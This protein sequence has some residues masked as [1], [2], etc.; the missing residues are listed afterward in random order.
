MGSSTVN[1]QRKSQL[2]HLVALPLMMEALVILEGNN[3]VST[4]LV[5]SGNLSLQPVNDHLK[6]QIGSHFLKSSVVSQ[7]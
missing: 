7:K 3:R 6:V 4:S 1:S 2:S 5:I